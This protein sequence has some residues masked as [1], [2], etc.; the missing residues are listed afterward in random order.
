MDPPCQPCHRM[1]VRFPRTRGDGPP[2]RCGR[3]WEATFPP[4]SRGW[5]PGLDADL[6]PE[7]VSP[8]LA[9]MDP[10][11]ARAGSGSRRFPRTRGDGPGIPWLPRWPAWFPPHSRGW[12]HTPRD[13]APRR[14]VSPALAGMDPHP[15][16]RRT[17]A[18]RFPRTRGDGPPAS[19]LEGRRCR[20][21]PHS[22]GWTPSHR[23][24]GELQGVSPALAGMDPEL[25]SWPL[26]DPRFPRTR[27]DGPS[28]I[29]ARHS[30]SSF[31]PH[32][33]GWTVVT[34]AR[35]GRVT[36]SPA[37]AGIDPTGCWRPP[38]AAC[39]PRTRGDGPRLKAAWMDW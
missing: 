26:R 24:A 16:G 22:R 11:S 2:G 12:T 13:G 38:W 5:T 36:V 14:H 25:S 18:P 30:R 19:L 31:P 32:S 21:P 20:F 3:P 28:S 9:G 1:T 15:P 27:G 39:F 23:G 29:Q 37:L 7:H 6:R 33:R 10:G 8:A 17:P 34:V 35:F 4:H